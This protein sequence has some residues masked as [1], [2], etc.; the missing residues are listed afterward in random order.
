MIMLDTSFNSLI[1]ISLSSLNGQEF[2]YNENLILN[3]YP[4]SVTV[5]LKAS[6]VGKLYNFLDC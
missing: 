6:Y 1:S 5:A 4:R 3:N 2:M